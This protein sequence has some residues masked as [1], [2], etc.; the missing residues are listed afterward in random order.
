MAYRRKRFKKNF[1]RKR[2]SA[3]RRS[4]VKKSSGDGKRPFKVR[5]TQ[6]LGSTGGGVIQVPISLTSPENVVS[7]SGTVEDWSSITALFDNFKVCALKLRYIPSFPNNT[8]AT[9]AFAPLYSAVDY[10]EVN[11]SSCIGTIAEAI[12]YENMKV[13]NMYR[14][15]KRYWKV[16]K[17]AF[18]GYAVGY[19][20]VD[21]PY[22]IGQMC[23]YGEGFTAS[24]TYGQ[25][26]ITYYIICKSRI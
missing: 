12:N 6:T 25:L 15:W 16:R 21:T 11:T 9:T 14:P 2:Y 7:G 20:E 4:S 22:N 23:L 3:R 10:D 17:L 19:N 13:H 18:P 26:I 1:R 24:T 5:Y 8:S